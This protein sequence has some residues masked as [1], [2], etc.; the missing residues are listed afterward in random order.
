V[1]NVQNAPKHPKFAPLIDGKET[2]SSLL[3]PIAKASGDRSVICVLQL[4][5][6]QPKN[7]HDSKKQAG[8]KASFRADDVN[9]IQYFSLFSGNLFEEALELQ[10]AK[11]TDEYL[12]QSKYCVQALT[13]ISDML[14]S[15]CP[16]DDFFPVVC[17]EATKLLNCD[18]ASLFLV[19]DNAKGNG[20]ELWSKIA[21]GVPPISLPLKENS[22][23]GSTV[24]GG[25][26][27]NIPN[28]YRDSRFDPSWD[29]KTNYRTY[30]ILCCPIINAQE[31]DV[32][33]C[34]Q[35]INKK[36]KFARVDSEHSFFKGIDQELAR[37]FC[38]VI[39]I[40]VKNSAAARNAEGSVG[41]YAH[42]AEIKQAS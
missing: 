22:I 32:L 35:L 15:G 3:V 12:E 28:A 4:R 18:R 13:H 31:G 37:D 38:S 14:A 34:L 1:V 40:A 33:G 7:V 17:T 8:S 24:M 42:V 27:V 25:E 30:S 9:F 36:D 19:R 20:R 41:L 29:K 26:M 11:E 16:L 23:A 39:A 10:K 21:M 6:K 2:L 5:N